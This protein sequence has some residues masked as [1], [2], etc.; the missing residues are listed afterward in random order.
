MPCIDHEYK[1]CPAYIELADGKYC[2]VPGCQRQK[3]ITQTSKAL[4]EHLNNDLEDVVI[5][6]K[7][8]GRQGTI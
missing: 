5:P 4:F 2:T 3:A 7:T 1:N 6:G 8:G